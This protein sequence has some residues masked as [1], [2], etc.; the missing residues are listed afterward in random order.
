MAATFVVLALLFLEWRLVLLAIPPLVFLAFAGMRAVPAPV[1]D[2]VREVSRDRVLV[3]PV[4][5]A[6]LERRIAAFVREKAA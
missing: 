1:L 6:E 2:V 5:L 3:K 4:E